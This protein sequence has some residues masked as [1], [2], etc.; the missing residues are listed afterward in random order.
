MANYFETTCT[1]DK[2][3]PNGTVKRAT[4]HYLVDALSF[5]EAEARTTQERRPYISGDFSV[6]TAKRTRITEIFGD[7]DSDRFYLVKVSFITIDEKAGA[8]KRTLSQILV[9]APDFDAALRIFK[10]GMKGTMADYEITSLA[11]TQILEVYK[12]KQ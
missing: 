2:M 10:E 5:T 7:L 3:Q 12:A 6:R 1:Y 4:E 8:E 11:E 9:A